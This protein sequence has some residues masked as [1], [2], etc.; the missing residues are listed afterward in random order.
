MPRP[1][2]FEHEASRAG[3]R[4]RLFQSADLGGAIKLL[5]CRTNGKKCKKSAR[6]RARRGL[7][8]FF[9]CHWPTTGISVLTRGS[10]V[11]CRASTINGYRRRFGHWARYLI[12]S[13]TLASFLSAWV[14]VFSPPPSLPSSFFYRTKCEVSG[15]IRIKFYNQLSAE[16]LPV[17]HSSGTDAILTNCWHN[18]G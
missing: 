2:C 5:Y 7:K 17:G 13:P 15:A 1:I 11:T 8:R 4:P 14:F 16:L 3:T 10:P 9:T 6:T 18:I 12:A